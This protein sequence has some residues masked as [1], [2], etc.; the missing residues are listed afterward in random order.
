MGVEGELGRAIGSKAE[1]VVESGKDDDLRAVIEQRR[2]FLTDCQSEVRGRESNRVARGEELEFER[3]RGPRKPHPRPGPVDLIEPEVGLRI[4]PI[5]DR[6]DVPG[7]GWFGVR[8]R[9]D[10]APLLHSEVTS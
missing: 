5:G 9:R 2:V 3:G 6:R 7:T 1:F 8:R 10:W 4:Q